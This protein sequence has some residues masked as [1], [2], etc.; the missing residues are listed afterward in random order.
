MLRSYANILHLDSL[1][2]FS[3]GSLPLLLPYQ[4][5]PD[6]R[7]SCQLL[8]FQHLLHLVQVQSFILDKG[9]RQLSSAQ[10]NGRLI[11]ADLVQFVLVVF[12]TFDRSCHAVIQESGR[13]PPIHQ[14]SPD[15][16]SDLAFDFVLLLPRQV[17]RL[18]ISMCYQTDF[19]TETVVLS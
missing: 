11:S 5:L 3:S 18:L 19:I 17:D 2:D 7:Y 12:Q 15:S 6:I 9:V 14:G 16:P 4:T 13:Q 1:H 8:P 10:F